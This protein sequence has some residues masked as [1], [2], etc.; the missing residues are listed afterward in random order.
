MTNAV[1]ATTLPSSHISLDAASALAPFTMVHKQ[2][3]NQHHHKSPPSNS[4]ISR[5]G[6]VVGPLVCIKNLRDN[7]HGH[8]QENTDGSSSGGGE[9]RKQMGWATA[10]KAVMTT[11]QPQ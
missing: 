10:A 9:D 2:H 6:D 7:L 4:S 3:H 11:P 1:G 8:S 5:G